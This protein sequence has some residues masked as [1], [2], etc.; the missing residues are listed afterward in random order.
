[1]PLLFQSA[2]PATAM[3]PEAQRVAIAEACGWKRGIPL[4]D[5][6]GEICQTVTWWIRPESYMSDTSREWS[7]LPDYLHD[8]NACHE[9]EKVLTQ[10]QKERYGKLLAVQGWSWNIWHAPAPVRC[11]A[12]L[13]AIGRWLK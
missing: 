6:S 10:E 4:E 1:M 7:V 13:K 12:F 8:L 5:D 2:G 3:T 9:M 11:D